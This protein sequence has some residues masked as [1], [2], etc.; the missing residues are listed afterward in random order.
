MA[1]LT[2]DELLAELGVEVEPANRGK[3]TALEERIIAG[4]EDIERYF[5]THGHLPR[6]GEHLDILERLYAVRLDRLRTTAE[7]LSV[8]TGLDKHGLLSMEVGVLPVG[9]DLD[10]EDLLSELGV[11]ADDD[12]NVAI[13]KHV[14]SREDKRAAEEI[15]NRTACQDFENF[16]PLFEVAEA[17]LQ[18][19]ARL[20]RRFAGDIN[21]SKGE[22]FIVGGQLAYVADK[23]ATFRTPN[24]EPDARLKLIYSN[25]TESNLLQRSLQRALYK[26]EAG[27]RLTDPG[28]LNLFSDDWEDDEVTSG[29]IYVL[30]SHSDH[31]FIVE[32]RGLVHKIGVTGGSV[33]ARISNAKLDSTYLLA[34]VEIVASYKMSGINR[35]K[36]ETVLHRIF[37]AAQI[38]VTIQDR[39]GNPVQP[40]E[41]FLVPLHVIDEAVQYIKD[42]SI[43]EL[44][45]DP[46][47]ARLIVRRS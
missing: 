16:K 43:T 41:W 13:L 46:S 39:F 10:D 2:D 31:P 28:A 21:I 33:E 44:E 15:A 14:V 4:F 35:G 11:E 29:T 36:L 25:G 34:D 12:T 8:L 6:H 17:E 19:G 42:G 9:V 32:H 24:G 20:T 7:A 3:H 40:K 5:E 38:E 23:G 45:Y 30:R 27:R 37:T 47:E 26:D 22:F 18:S 1:E